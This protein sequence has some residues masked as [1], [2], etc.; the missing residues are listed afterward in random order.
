MENVKMK[1]A[2]GTL[3]M[4][5]GVRQHI[6]GIKKYS[7]QKI[8]T[9][10]SERLI[11][12]LEKTKK[13]GSYS[14]WKRWLEYTKLSHYDVVH[15]HVDPW[16]SRLCLSSQSETCKWVHTYHTLYFEED[17]ISGVLQPWQKEINK[18]L[19][20]DAS[21]ADLRISV[22]KWLKE[23][24]EYKYSIQ[25]T[26]VHGGVDIDFCDK[27]NP[28][29]FSKKFG[30]RDF[31][32]FVGYLDSIKNPY[33]F[34]ELAHRMPEVKFVMIGR[35][36]DATHIKDMY[37]VNLPKNLVMMGEM[38]HMD[39]LDAMSACKVFVMTSKRE[40]CPTAL[41][42]AMGLEKT[43]VVPAHSGC[44]DI[45]QSEDYGFLY[46]PGSADDMV[47]KTKQAIESKSVGEKARERVL[48]NYDWKV[49]AKAIDSI[50]ESCS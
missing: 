44:K 14:V 45:V 23:Y 28:D 18:S 39:V 17:Y 27:A 33:L 19:L 12:F 5:G 24:L 15:S 47:E 13:H 41:L 11:A 10:P 32:L 42:E 4:F 20:E 49:V 36:I 40:G 1:V 25:T 26:L 2:V 30:V 43:V 31:I 48:Q 29:R 38:R 3:E 22:S 46:E 35:D 34:V 50:Y 7:S 6:L 37:R 16:F 9:V 21:K 8:S